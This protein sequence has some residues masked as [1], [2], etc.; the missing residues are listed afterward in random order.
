MVAA[1]AAP[2]HLHLQLVALSLTRESAG[3]TGVTTITPG[4]VRTEIKNDESE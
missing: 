3:W 1:A 4:S 2:H